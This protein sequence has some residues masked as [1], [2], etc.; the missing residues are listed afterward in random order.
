MK[1]KKNSR[2]FTLIELLVVIAII[3]ILASMLLP[4]LNKARDTAKTIVCTNN[5]KQI[6][7]GM[8]SYAS[9]YDGYFPN[10]YNN[11]G[12]KKYWS[13]DLATLGYLPEP[14]PKQMLYLCPTNTVKNY[15]YYK[16]SKPELYNNNYVYNAEL[17]WEHNYWDQEAVKLSQIEKPTEVAMVSDAGMRNN[18][19]D[20]LACCPA[21]N[22]RDIPG[23]PNY[24]NKYTQ[25]AFVHHNS[26]NIVWVDGHVEAVSLRNISPSM[27]LAKK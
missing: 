8:L 9:D 6:G 17:D 27:W 11:V 26:C 12:T 25:I 14:G 2:Y 23:G 21:I 20:P 15:N 5:L 16:A 4:A 24:P 19:G 10:Y 18:E 7:L 1:N 13:K 22:Y 3:A